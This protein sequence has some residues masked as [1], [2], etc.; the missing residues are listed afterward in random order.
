MY[1]RR[2]FLKYA[3]VIRGIAVTGNPSVSAKGKSMS[4]I[5]GTDLFG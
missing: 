3:G 5:A 4:S 1:S 2:E